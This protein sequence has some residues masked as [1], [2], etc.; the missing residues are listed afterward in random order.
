MQAGLYREEKR[1]H[2]H[3]IESAI[4]NMKIKFLPLDEKT[5]LLSNDLLKK[6]EFLGIFDSIHAATSIIHNQTLL[7]TDHIYPLLDE[8]V[9]R[10]ERKIHG[11]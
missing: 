4:R 10:P 3:D 7:S 2:M 11:F 1:D 9:S 6:Y 5:T 8:L